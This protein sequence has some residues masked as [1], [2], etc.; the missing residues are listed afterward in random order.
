MAGF[1]L[2]RIILNKGLGGLRSGI[3][4]GGICCLT[5]GSLPAQEADAAVVELRE[6]IARL[7]ELRSME[8]RERADWEARKA[9]MA[10]LLELQRR[11][12]ALLDEELAEAG[13]SAGGHDEAAEGMR[14]EIETLREARAL[15]RQAL[16]GAVPRLL[17]LERRFPQPLRDECE[18]ERGQLE[19]W[20]AENEPREALQALIAILGKAEQ[21]NRRVTRARDVRD[22][23]VVEVIYL[24]LGRAFYVGRDGAAGFGE[25]S[26][27][28]GWTWR[29]RRDLHGAV[30]E[31][32]R[33]LDKQLPPGRVNLPLQVR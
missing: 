33:M 24:G 1:R 18:V 23:R 25:P 17:A 2:L 16:Q 10:E 22:G 9:E 14:E 15:A 26:A 5:A 28:N 4:A 27:E 7:V 20:R 29:E 32:L 6:S 31:A 30:G 11:E 19:T 3:L 12:L 13:A 21:F 8:S